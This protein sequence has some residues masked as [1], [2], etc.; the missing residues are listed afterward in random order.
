MKSERYLKLYGANC[1]SCTYTIERV[2]RRLSHVEN[3]HVD[4]S[5]SQVK[6]VFDS[7]DAKEQR[8]TLA[9]L[10]EVIQRIGYDATVVS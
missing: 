9:K 7:A 8:V 3:V 4:T 6:V 5:N 10:I 2:G 1:P